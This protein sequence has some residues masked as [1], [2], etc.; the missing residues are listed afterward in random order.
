LAH[1]EHNKPKRSS[2]YFLIIAGALLLMVAPTQYSSYPILSITALI[3]GFII[4]SAG[5]YLK[6]VQGRKI[7]NQS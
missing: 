2:S 3:F 6:F 1:D 4:G 5:F 7:R